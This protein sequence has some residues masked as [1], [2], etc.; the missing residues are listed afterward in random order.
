MAIMAI[1][2]IMAI[3]VI[4]AIMAIMDNMAIMAIMAINNTL[5]RPGP[6]AGSLRYSDPQSGSSQL[7][8]SRTRPR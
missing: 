8:R 7:A 1:L 5:S 4:M 3:M 6:R 2:D